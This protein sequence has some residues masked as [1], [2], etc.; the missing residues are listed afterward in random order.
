MQADAQVA[1]TD[2]APIGQAQVNGSLGAAKLDAREAMFG[3]YDAYI[4]VRTVNCA[5]P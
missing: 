3:R 5:S 2:F 4:A 1:P